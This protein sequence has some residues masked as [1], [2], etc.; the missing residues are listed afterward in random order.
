[1]KTIPGTNYPLCM[2]CEEE[3]A[4]M[5]KGKPVRDDALG[6][7]CAE[8]I[9]HLASATAALAEAG[10]LHPQPATQTPSK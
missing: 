7:V 10:L 2:C 4:A 5:K 3:P 8:C 9:P 6:P 1:M